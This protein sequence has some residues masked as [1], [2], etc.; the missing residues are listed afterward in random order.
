MFCAQIIGTD[1]C[2]TIRNEQDITVNVCPAGN[3][4]GA[5]SGDCKCASTPGVTVLN[6]K[7]NKC[8]C[9]NNCP[10]SADSLRGQCTPSTDIKDKIKV[11]N[12]DLDIND[13]YIP[14]K[15][16]SFG[17]INR[18]KGVPTFLTDPR[19]R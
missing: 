14:D 9:P 5:I 10:Y 4:I 12:Q 18:S 15:V 8:T 11:N 2:E 3:G 19:L 7:Y 6:K 16:C 13:L 17:T 1:R